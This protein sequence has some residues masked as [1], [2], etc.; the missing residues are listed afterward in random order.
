MADT[1]SPEKFTTDMH[2]KLIDDGPLLFP[3]LLISGI[4]L[5]PGRGAIFLRQPVGEDSVYAA[6][7]SGDP[8]VVRAELAGLREKVERF[9]VF[10][11]KLIGAVVFVGAHRAVG[12]YAC[13]PGQQTGFRGGAFF[14][15]RLKVLFSPR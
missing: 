4:G 2:G 1:Q 7:N 5:R 13:F 8:G 14:E 10:P 12:R 9:P 15:Q 3:K 6:G 11:L